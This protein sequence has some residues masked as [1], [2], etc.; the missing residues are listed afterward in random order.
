MVVD[1]LLVLYEPNGA[2]FIFDCAFP[3]LSA[4]HFTVNEPLGPHHGVGLARSSLAVDKYCAVEAIESSYDHL[5]HCLLVDVSVRVLR[6]VNQVVVEPGLGLDV[7]SSGLA[8]SRATG[9]HR[10]HGTGASPVVR[11]PESRHLP[12]VLTSGWKLSSLSLRSL[13]DAG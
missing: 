1:V 9:R 4:G 7:Y 3:S 6:V 12:F 13:W 5:P 8:V 2:L 11:K 10:F